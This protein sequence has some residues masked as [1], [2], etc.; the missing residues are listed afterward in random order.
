MVNKLW[1]Y[2]YRSPISDNEE[3]ARKSDP[4]YLRILSAKCQCP[5]RNTLVRGGSAL[6]RSWQAEQCLQV[7]LRSSLRSFAISKDMRNTYD[8][9]HPLFPKEGLYMEEHPT[10]RHIPSI[11]T[12]QEVI[13]GYD[14]NI[15]KT[16]GTYTI[17]GAIKNL[18]TA[19]EQ[20]GP[21]VL[22]DGDVFFV[23]GDLLDGDFL[24]EKVQFPTMAYGKALKL[25]GPQ[26]SSAPELE[27]V[28][29]HAIWSER[30]A[31]WLLDGYLREE[32]RIAGEQ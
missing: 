5:I 22:P 29:K 21:F 2:L 8:R 11:N 17:E 16:G 26:G 15:N 4:E 25:Q 24:L 13:T 12:S 6:T 14:I 9:V 23:I 1:T 3:Y 10:L 19:E 27:E 18:T 20:S 32:E 30:L 31:A 7:I 28:I